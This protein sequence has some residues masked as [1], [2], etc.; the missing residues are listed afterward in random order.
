[1]IYDDDVPSASAVAVEIHANFKRKMRPGGE[2]DR[3]LNGGEPIEKR[4]PESDGEIALRKR[5]IEIQLSEYETAIREAKLWIR[6][7]FDR[8]RPKGMRKT[9]R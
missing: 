3:I 2:I 8:R 9:K 6:N 7:W 1:M 5:Q 4:A